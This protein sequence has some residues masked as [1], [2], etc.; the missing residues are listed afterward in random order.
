[1][2]YSCLGLTSDRLLALAYGFFGQAPLGQH[3]APTRHLALWAKERAWSVLLH[4][5]VAALA[6]LRIIGC[7]ALTDIR[8]TPD[9]IGSRSCRAMSSSMTHLS[10]GRF[11][12]LVL[13]EP[14]AEDILY[15]AHSGEIDH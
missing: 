15:D 5:P 8:L 13:K 6:Y 10:A 14:A 3:L 4:C 11:Q 2:S 1:M 9:L 7:P 12:L